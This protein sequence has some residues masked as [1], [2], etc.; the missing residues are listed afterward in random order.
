MGAFTWGMFAGRRRAPVESPE[1]RAQRER[2]AREQAEARRRDQAERDA[3]DRA[4]LARA[5]EQ[6]AERERRE[7]VERLSREFTEAVRRHRCLFPTDSWQDGPELNFWGVPRRRRRD[8]RGL[9]GFIGRLF[10]A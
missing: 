9:V 8:E 7:H 5:E 10:D 4:A 1:A 3:Q 6:R 2:V